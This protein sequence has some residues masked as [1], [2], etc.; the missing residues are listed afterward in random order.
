MLGERR[1]VQLK[2]L[3]LNWFFSGETQAELEA[4]AVYQCI[5]CPET[6]SGIYYKLIFQTRSS[7]DMLSS[8]VEVNEEPAG[9]RFYSY[10]YFSD[11]EC[12]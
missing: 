11:F 3:A 10:E 2:P 6:P 12:S 7:G 1:T 8:V 4:S 5:G 9:R